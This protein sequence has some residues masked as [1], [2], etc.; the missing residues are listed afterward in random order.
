MRSAAQE[1][2]NRY[3]HDYQE[4]CGQNVDLMMEELRRWEAADATILYKPLDEQATYADFVTRK[5][6]TNETE[7]VFVIMCQ[8]WIRDANTLDKWTANTCA[9]GN[10]ALMTKT[11]LDLPETYKELKLDM[12]NVYAALIENQKAQKSSCVI[13]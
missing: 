9:I 3:F 1:A 4:W 6:C 7:A 5:M 11:A 12:T 8:E 10:V 13:I 2:Q